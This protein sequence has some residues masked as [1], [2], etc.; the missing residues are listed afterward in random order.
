MEYHTE[1]FESG[2]I[3]RRYQTKDGIRVGV[4]KEYY[5]NGRAA[6]ETFYS[7]DGELNGFYQEF[8]E[9]E[10]LVKCIMYKRGKITDMSPRDLNK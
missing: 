9:D 8:N 3:K 4:Y 6:V 1:Y 2:K 10:T 5:E 7:A